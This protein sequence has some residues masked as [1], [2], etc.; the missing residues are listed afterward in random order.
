MLI[1]LN[2]FN[3]PPAAISYGSTG[4]LISF[5]KTQDVKMGDN[6]FEKRALTLVKS[7][8]GISRE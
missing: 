6:Y 5:R 3:T 8:S 2:A 7:S 1:D 4:T